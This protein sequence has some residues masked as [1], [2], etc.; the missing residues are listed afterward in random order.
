MKCALRKNWNEKNEIPR[1]WEVT[2]Q[3]AKVKQNK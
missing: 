1:G 3:S 2:Q